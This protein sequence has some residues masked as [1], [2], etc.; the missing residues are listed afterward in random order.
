MC[1]GLSGTILRVHAGVAVTSAQVISLNR[2]AKTCNVLSLSLPPSCSY[3]SELAC[4][5][6]QCVSDKKPHDTMMHWQHM[7]K[8]VSALHSGL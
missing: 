2:L 3:V 4:E 1:L 5:H 8:A 6:A 7:G